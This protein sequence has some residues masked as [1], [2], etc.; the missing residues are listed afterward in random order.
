MT[1]S[2]N[3]VLVLGA[4]GY[5]GSNIVRALSQEPGTHVVAACRR[6]ER[7][8]EEL[9][10][11]ARVGDLRDPRYRATLF[12]G[13][14][15]VCFAAAWSAL[16]GHRDASRRLFLEP[17]L[18]AMTEAQRAGV[19]RI[20]FLSAIDVKNVAHSRS[21]AVRNDLASVWPHL[22]NVIAIEEHLA[23]L[24]ENGLQGV[25]VRC[26]YFAG[27][28][29]QLGILPVLLPRLR[30][31]LV[32]Y[33][34]R[35]RAPMRLVDGRD[36]GRAFALLSRARRLQGMQS[37][38]VTADDC[39]TFAEFLYLLNAEFGYPLPW[40]SVSYDAA[41]RFAR[42]AEAVSYL[43]PFEPLLTRSIVFLS[44]PAT[45]EDAPLREL[46]FRPAHRWQDSV[47]AQVQEIHGQRIKSRLVDRHPRALPSANHG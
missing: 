43:T 33:I 46:G 2:R 44:E 5:I 31:R 16:F 42:V 27:P 6:P 38:E 20:L 10:R 21:A 3:R 7:L 19:S 13:V 34:E 25:A 1:E 39:P 36:V 28:G 17:T 15:T 14:D 9:R 11:E 30:A 23:S 4:S 45:V 24:A 22:A 35:G 41:Y 37:F 26:G 29:M 40:F 12:E 47:R 18:A 8:P 32:P